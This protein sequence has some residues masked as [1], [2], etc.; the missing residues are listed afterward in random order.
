[1]VARGRRWGSPALPSA[2][3]CALRKDATDADGLRPIAS[4][5]VLRRVVGRAML[6]VEHTA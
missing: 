4:G 1:M 3:L 2:R 6:R 5:E